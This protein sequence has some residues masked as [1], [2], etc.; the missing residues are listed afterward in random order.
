VYSD[1]IACVIPGT[2]SSNAIPVQVIPV[3]TPS[4]SIIASG[5]TICAGSPVNFTATPGGGGPAPIF[6]WQVN[7]NPVGTNSPAYSS[8]TL[9]NGDIVS[10]LLNSNAV[11]SILATAPSNDIVVTVNAVTASAIHIDYLPATICSGKSVVFT[12]IP[13][14]EGPAPVYQW[15]V[16]GANVGTNGPGY[17]S[18][19]LANGDIVSCL[20][21]DPAGCISPSSDKVP[22]TVSP[23]PT[24]ATGRTVIISK[25]QSAALDL[26]PIGDITTWLWS[27]ATGLSDPAIPNPVASP[28]A[29]TVYTLL[30]TS[31]EG[32]E[33]SGSI[34]VGV[35]SKLSIPTAFTPNGDGR[36]DVFYVMG[37]PLG[38]RIKDFGIFN[39][40]GQRIF[41]VHDVPSDDPGFGWNGRIKGESAPPGAYAYEILM[42]FADGTQQVYKGTLL[43]VR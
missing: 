43:L 3:V 17:N 33:T 26:S 34:T 24:L 37:G 10:C 28:L 21:S 13:T 32:C 25:G 15:Q 20:L 2:N 7:G 27:P 41:Q 1:N 30:A 22:L 12:A 39:R 14:G 29:T 5:T 6:Q 16:N 31:A 9:A 40:W 18:S 4:L 8:S 38:S 23:S 11:C 36:N 35:Y 19:T 42:S